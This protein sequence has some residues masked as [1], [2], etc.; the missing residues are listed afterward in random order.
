[1]KWQPA[2]DS[3]TMN[4]CVQ[5]MTFWYPRLQNIEEIHD[6]HKDRSNQWIVKKS[7]NG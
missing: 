1:L 3:E 6:T 7:S 4:Q 5:L 2:L